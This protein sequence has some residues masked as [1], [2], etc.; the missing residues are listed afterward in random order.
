MWQKTQLEL[1]DAEKGLYLGHVTKTSRGA[2]CLAQVAPGALT[3]ASGLSLSISQPCFPLG[4]LQSQAGKMVTSDLLPRCSQPLG[5]CLSATFLPKV[6][7][8]CLI[9]SL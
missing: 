6:P 9:G 2:W 1:A 4:L 5:V 7:G 3:M 8:M